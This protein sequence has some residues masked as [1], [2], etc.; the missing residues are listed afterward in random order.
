MVWCRQ[1]RRSLYSGRPAAEKPVSVSRVADCRCVFLGV[2]AHDASPADSA[3]EKAGQA[4]ELSGEY[5]WNAGK[6]AVTD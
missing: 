5:A 2:S 1:E 3:A 4:S 6:A